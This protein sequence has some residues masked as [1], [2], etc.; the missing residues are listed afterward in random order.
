MPA[1]PGF[2]TCVGKRS[3]VDRHSTNAEVKQISVSLGALPGVIARFEGG[4]FSGTQED[5]ETSQAIRFNA[6][7]LPASNGDPPPR[8]FAH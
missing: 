5:A 6:R 8:A 2:Q 4:L 7:R 3:T 1:S